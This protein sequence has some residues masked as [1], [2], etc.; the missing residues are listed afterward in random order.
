MDWRQQL[1]VRILLTIARIVAVGGEAELS[2]EI[3]NL[4]NHINTLR[5]PQ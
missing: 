3:K 4:A 2:L 1:V 5:V